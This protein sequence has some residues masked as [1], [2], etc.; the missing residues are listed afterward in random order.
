MTTTK[1][2]QLAQAVT[3]N[4]TICPLSDFD[5]RTEPELKHVEKGLEGA[6]WFRLGCGMW[7]DPVSRDR[8][9]VSD[10]WRI[11]L[12]RTVGWTFVAN[13]PYE[14]FVPLECDVCGNVVWYTGSASDR[15]SF[16][17]KDGCCG[18]V[19]AASDFTW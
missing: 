4:M 5:I 7:E 16:C 1:E 15:P 9:T 19:V 17:V 10:A 3:D 11:F 2:Q 18:R 6:R 13:A 12:L 14:E 8:M